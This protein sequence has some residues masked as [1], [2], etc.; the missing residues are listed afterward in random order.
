MLLSSLDRRIPL[1]VSKGSR[2]GDGQD[3]VRIDPANEMKPR[4]IA[5]VAEELSNTVHRELPVGVHKPLSDPS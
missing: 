1:P 5:S 4:L 2:R 3:G